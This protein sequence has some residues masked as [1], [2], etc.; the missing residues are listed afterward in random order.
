MNRLTL[1]SLARLVAAV[2]G[3]VIV[4][5][6]AM[7]APARRTLPTQTVIAPRPP[8]IQVIVF[9]FENNSTF[10]G[11]AFGEAMSS[12]VK[13][14]LIS[15]GRFSV[16]TYYAFS[17]LLQ[18]LRAENPNNQDL[19]RAVDAS[20]GTVDQPRAM[21]VARA[22]GGEAALFGAVEEYR[23]DTQGRKAEITVSASLVNLLT[24]APIRTAGVTGSATGREGSAESDVAAEAARDAAV[25]LLR[26]MG[27]DPNPPA[28]VV[29]TTTRRRR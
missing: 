7:A 28:P 2:L 14:G 10:G 1:H 6:S 24:G 29:T 9:P 16:A 4:G 11:P 20:K 17:P 13:G 8:Q 21:V 26:E 15:S 19:A 3:A 18:R 22:M 23:Y 5:G 25:R 27:I 12:A